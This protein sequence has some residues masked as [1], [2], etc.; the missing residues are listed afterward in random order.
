MTSRHAGRIEVSSRISYNI[1]GK[2]C[3]EYDSLKK[4]VKRTIHYARQQIAMLIRLT[5]WV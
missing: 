2:G 4:E 3:K 1:N 5:E